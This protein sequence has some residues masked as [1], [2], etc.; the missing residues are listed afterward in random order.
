MEALEQWEIDLRNQ[1]SEDSQKESFIKN[2]QSKQK[3]EN[4]LTHYFV[5]SILLF[6]IFFVYSQKSNGFISNWFSSVIESD[7]S[8]NPFENFPNSISSD[9]SSDIHQ[10][11]LDIEKLRQDFDAM[12]NKLKWNSDRINLMG[13]LLNENFVIVS[14][15]YDRSNLIF[16][17]SDW[18]INKMPQYLDIQEKDKEYLQKFIKPISR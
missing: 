4:F 11:R 6:A 2:E 13:M 8:E 17:N 1:L 9:N 16:F 15:G 5:I 18:T 10:I 7:K 3:E 14:N 12:N